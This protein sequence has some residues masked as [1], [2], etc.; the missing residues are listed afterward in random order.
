MNLTYFT[1]IC[2][3]AS[4]STINKRR[5]EMNVQEKGITIIDIVYL[6]QTGLNLYNQLNQTNSKHIEKNETH[7]EPPLDEGVVEPESNPNL[8]KDT[9][10]LFCDLVVNTQ[11]TSL[12]AKILKATVALGCGFGAV[13]FALKTL[14]FLNPAEKEDVVESPPKKQKNITATA[15]Q[16]DSQLTHQ[17]Q[18]TLE[19][20]ETNLK[21]F[22]PLIEGNA[23]FSRNEDG[24][25]ILGGYI[26]FK[27]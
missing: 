7:I 22:D 12:P 5:I 10:K 27:I 8:T 23:N 24:N 14:G 25:L 2:K 1:I 4:C 19:V 21:Q 11:D 26:I 9:A 3:L 17:D 15:T 20:I 18:E 6:I 16:S 13:C